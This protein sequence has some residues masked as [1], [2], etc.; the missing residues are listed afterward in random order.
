[1]SAFSLKS[2]LQTQ[3]GLSIGDDKWCNVLHSMTWNNTELPCI[4]HASGLV[5]H[6]RQST[7]SECTS[8]VSVNLRRG[9]AMSID[10]SVI[11]SPLSRLNNYRMVLRGIWWDIQDDT[12]VV[13][14]H[15]LWYQVKYL[16]NHWLNCLEMCDTNPCPLWDEI[17]FN[18]RDQISI[19]PKPLFIFASNMQH[20]RT[21]NDICINRS[22]TLI[23]LSTR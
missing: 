14:W 11:S 8:A 3:K 23:P 1:M 19:C 2:P 15:F 17:Q 21:N 10:W 20:M 22:R 13:P 5:H 12:L 6:A 4:F 9:M 16:N 7:V 18:H